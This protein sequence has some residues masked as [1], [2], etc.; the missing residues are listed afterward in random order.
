MPLGIQVTNNGTLDLAADL[1]ALSGLTL[2]LDGTGSFPASQIASFTNG[3]INITGGTSSFAAL[4]DLDGSSVIVNGGASL[5]LLGLT[6]YTGSTAYQAT[7]TLEATGAGSVL[8]LSNLTALSSAL[9]ADSGVA[10]QALAGGNVNLPGLT[11]I[12]SDVGFETDGAGSVLDL[13]QLASF[14][15]VG[16]WVT[17]GIQVSDNGT[18][19]LPAATFTMPNSGTGATINVPQFPAEAPVNLPITGTFSGGSTFNIAAGDTITLSGGTYTGGTT[20]NILD[21]ATVTLSA[22]TF[23]GGGVFNVAQGSTC[24]IT[25]N[26]EVAGALTGSGS[27]T[28]QI[29]SLKVGTGGLTLNFPGNMLQWT[30]GGISTALGDLTNLGT[31]TLVGSGAKT[32][33]FGGT[34]DNF[35]TII[36]TGSGDLALDADQSITPSTLMNE[37]GAS[38]FIESDSGIA[39]AGGGNAGAVV[40]AGTICFEAD[41]GS[42]SIFQGSLSNTGTIEVGFG[43]FDLAADSIAQISGRS[44]TGGTWS[45]LRGATLEFP[46]GTAITSNAAN[47]TLSGSGATIAGIAGLTTNSGSFGVTDG[48]TFTTA[49]DFS[50]SGILTVGDALSVAGNFTQTSAGTLD[51]QIGGT[52]ASG[53]FGH[54]SVNGSATLAGTFNLALVDDFSPLTNQT[55]GVMSFKSLSGAFSTFTGMDRSFSESLSPTSF[56]L[57]TSPLN[58][59]ELVATSVSGPTAVTAGQ[60]ITATWQASNN[61]SLPAVGNWQDSVYLSSTPAITSAS[62]YLGAVAHDGGL[63]ANG[64]YTGTYSGEIP[65]ILPGSYYLLVQVDSLYQLNVPD[66]A[67]TISAAPA[68]VAVSVPALTLGSPTSGSLTATNPEQYYQIAVQTAGTLQFTVSTASLDEIGT[69]VCQGA[70]PTSSNFQEGSNGANQTTQ[71]ATVPNTTFGTYY[72]LLHNIGGS[73]PASYTLTATQSNTLTVSS[74]S[75]FEGGDTGNMTMEIDGT[76]FTSNTTAS[77]TVLGGTATINAAIDYINAS[78]LFATFNLNREGTGYYTLTVK[79]GT[80]SVTEQSL[81]TVEANNKSGLDIG[82]CTPEYIRSGRTATITIGYTNLNN[83]DM[84]APLLE[85]S[86]TNP[87]VYFST[88]DDPNDY[89]Q[90]AEVLAVSSYGPAGVLEGDNP[91][92]FAPP[93]S[94]GFITLTLL[95]NDAIDG[96]SI[97]IQVSEIEA[98]QTIDWA[99]QEASLKPASIP[100][101]AWNVIY[102]NLLASVGTTTDSYNAALAQ[103]ATYLSGIGE[104]TAQ[105]SD[106]Q[107]SDVGRLW[108]FLVAQ[109]S[110]DF[111][112]TTLTSTTDSALS[113][114]G[115]L[116]LAID[117]TFMSSIDGRYTQGI[118]GMGWAT[119]W[120]TSL[121]VDSSGNVTIDSGGTLSYFPI[122]ANG[123]FLDTDT[124][125]GLLTESAGIYTFTDTSGTQ[126][127]FLANGLLNYEQDTNGNRITLGYNAQNQI[128][129][130]TYSNPADSSEPTEQLSLTYNAQGFVSQVADGT[131]NVWSYT[132][133][134]AGHLLSVT[135]PGNMTTSYT[136]DTGSN[137]ETANALLSITNPDGSQQNFTW[138]ATTGQLTGSSSNGGADAIAYTYPGEAEVEAT[139]SARDVSIV[140]Y[141]DLGSASRVQDPL[142]GISN[143]HYDNNGN[144]VSSTNA[145]GDA[146]QY[147]YDQKDNLTQIVNP[148]GQAVDMTYNWLSD[149]T[150][151]TDA[152]GNTTKYSYSSAGNLLSIAYPG[153]TQQSFTY[154]PLGNLSETVEQN[155]APL[156]CQYNAQGLVAEES[157]ADGTSETFAY[158]AHGNLL[159]AE[160]YSAADALTGTTT[161][162]Y[163]AANELTSISYPGGLSLRFTYNAQ[164]Q[165]TQSV[166]QS[167]YTINYSYD[168]QGR[169]SALTDGSGNL[170]V[171]Y[172]YNALGQLSEKENGN[173]TYTTCAYDAAGNLTSEINYA[174][175][176]GGTPYVPADSK[177]NSSF[178]CT[179]NVLDEMTSMTDTSGNVTSYAYDATG[180]LT[181]VKLPGGATITY[182]YNAAGDR[183]EVVNSGTPTSYTSNADNEITQVGS[184]TYTYDTNGNLHTA[185]N[186]S[187]TTTYAYNDLNLLVSITAPDGT[188]TTFQ[189]SPLGFLMGESVN[190][191]QT[192][193]LVDP[194]GLGNVAASY[195][196]GGAL[197]AH[198]NYGLGLVNQTGPSGAGYY[199]FDAS[200]NTVGITGSSG[201]YVNQYSYLPFG[202]TTTV[203]AALP[204]PFTFAGQVGVMQIGANLFNMRARN[205]TPAVG[206]FLSND[207]IGLAGG[208]SNIRKYV[209]NNPLSGTDPLGLVDIQPQLNQL[210]SD[211]AA[212][213]Q[214]VANSLAGAE[215]TSFTGEMMGSF[216][217]AAATAGAY[218]G[219]TFGAP[220][221]VLSHAAAGDLTQAIQ[222]GTVQQQIYGNIGKGAAAGWKAANLYKKSFN[223]NNLPATLNKL[224]YDAK[225]IVNKLAHDPNA[226]VGPAGYGTQGFIQPTGTCS[227]TAQFENDGGAAAQDVTVSEQLDSNL[228]WSTFQLGSFGFGSVNV[229]VPAG[230]TQYQTTVSYQNT[231][232]SSLNVA[233]A[234]DFNIQTGLLTAT[235][236]SL[237]P[238]TGQDPPGVFDGFLYPQSESPVGS[239]G[240]V[241]YTVQ[242]N[243]SL[244]NAAT[245]NQQAAVVF[246]ANAALDTAVV[247]NTIDSTVPVSSVA[248]LPALETSTNFTVNWSGQ[249]TGGSGIASYD[250]YDS[251]NGG[252]YTLWQSDTTATSAVFTGQVG[253]SYAFYSVAASNVGAVQSTP[254]AAQATTTVNPAGTVDSQGVYS[255]GYWYINVNGTMQIVAVPVSWA[256]ATPVT[257]DWNGGGKTEIGLFNQATA[258]W[259]LNT[260]GEG[261]FKSSE[262]FTFGFTGSNVFPVVGDWNG[263]GKTE[264]GVYC[265][266]AWFRDY[267]NSHTWD[268]TNQA[269]MAYLGW[270][271]GGTNTV[272]P[273]PGQWAGDGKTEMGVYCQGV[274]FL[275]STDS[276]KWD[277]GH[278]YWGW[279]G[280]LTPLV[281]NWTGSSAKSQF[282]VY[283]QG[284]WFLDYDNSHLWDA[285][286]QAALTFYG[287]A[288]AQ[289][290]VGV[291]GSGFQASA[292][293]A[294]SGVQAPM[295][296]AAQIQPPVGAAIGGGT[297]TL[298]LAASGQPGGDS[299]PASGIELPPAADEP[300]ASTAAE[301]P[302]PA[303]DP[304]AV[305]RID[306]S[307]V[308]GGQVAGLP[309][310]NASL[311]LLASNQLGRGVRST[312]ITRAAGIGIP[313]GPRRRGKV[314]R[315]FL[316]LPLGCLKYPYVDVSPDCLRRSPPT[317]ASKSDKRGVPI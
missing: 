202:E 197:V 82:L 1:T 164:G 175:S 36:Q 120:Q 272:I 143:Y 35:G 15:A 87:Y 28:V 154:D 132:Y 309:D 285:A 88:P 145:G 308:T 110:A 29:S 101:A 149:L 64:T 14:S 60:S 144:L 173:G 201:T 98:G 5:T 129:T 222:N 48:A 313:A 295:L 252:A 56:N 264:V 61:S 228:D 75:K 196:G 204:N 293:R 236:T 267:D 46:N 141:N 189:Y 116:S 128:V 91:G 108:S 153:G 57:L 303:L 124:E 119:S 241:Q 37:A 9:G 72:I 74:V 83:D 312:G 92:F 255:N 213:P 304:Q 253:D 256:G 259:W 234:L 22:G 23:V 2:A 177:V 42:A 158:D 127:V 216:G 157:F 126:Y 210:I 95:S 192:N 186:S 69:L 284:A 265:N 24:G 260:A 282:G 85:I 297:G 100:T 214:A 7:N 70:L 99:S 207:P 137:A 67:N 183:T 80:Q 232:G 73:L 172:A 93:G 121:S 174:P 176:T 271:D 250:V 105:V 77:L 269:T 195:N 161:L 307:A 306:L 215:A 38:Y 12:A 283:S 117:R 84:V 4:T 139:D 41:S 279:A 227:Y 280:T 30:A 76:N 114:P 16:D 310:L 134:T 266:G 26:A 166:D 277:G 123:V 278:T 199:D 44:L 152:G 133:D 6:S 10:V 206:Q 151:I 208:T 258:T 146:Y 200:G 39:S 106:D 251:V 193:Y 276:N 52:P 170:I 34:L 32:L 302:L 217:P 31:L 220:A 211:L 180:Q 188:V 27:G 229:T 311:D 68:L 294:A 239:D 115:G 225:Q 45:V 130:L 169:L 248:T 281:G 118:F 191:T 187:G 131:G 296:G 148:L 107:V 171:H 21:G 221:V 270:N 136:Y 50:N 140:W 287:W 181:Q 289:P 165:R 257:G 55:F 291:W 268:A 275:D 182:V 230:L 156:S 54:T 147:A 226:L 162:T 240:Y 274:W 81:F 3:T 263:E 233:V 245:I 316:A 63:A 11:A 111:P 122:Q 315:S 112:T 49:G 33:W 103:A 242:P 43:T 90:S 20:L 65:A 244:A 300:I 314:G 13:P 113:T 238:L 292:A 219:A 178:A 53:L 231:D 66:R 25:A 102:N 138:S 18:I 78:Q 203:S 305:D 155:G 79:D 246:D 163:N 159:T 86:S 290:V 190:G 167:G 205:Y 209:S 58:Q 298:G 224:K 286:N 273:V 19:D 184:T 301:T 97:P 288:G 223:K 212:L 40:N 135:A 109:A 62:T 47:I 89:V 96:D 194:T 254:A 299:G 235:F 150:S 17:P 179:Y 237:D 125:S 94:S 142:G 243:A 160:T 262:T 249:D 51:E 104:T 59:T 8:D 317:S 168:A 247:T 261:G 71:T 198:Y 185:T 218:I